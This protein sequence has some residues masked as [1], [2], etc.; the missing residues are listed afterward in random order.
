MKLAD[1]E[2]EFV[3]RADGDGFHKVETLAEAQ[4]LLFLCPK[5]YGANAGPVGTHSVLAWFKGRGVPDDAEPGPGRWEPSGTGFPDLTLNPS[6]DI[7]GFMSCNW[8][9]WI[10]NG[11]A[12]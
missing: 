4:G 1:L 8:H 9:G 11:E 5:C 10:Q 12:T 3:A 7:T 2:P 6:V